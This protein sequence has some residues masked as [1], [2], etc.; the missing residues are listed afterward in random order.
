M[1][2]YKTWK[3]ELDY[4]ITEEEKV[5]KLGDILRRHSC[6]PI[7]MNG[8]EQV[9][10]AQCCLHAPICPSFPLSSH[11]QELHSIRLCT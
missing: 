8:F 11:I 10:L 9:F 7:C 4:Q 3:Q 2:D 5:L 6:T 1:S